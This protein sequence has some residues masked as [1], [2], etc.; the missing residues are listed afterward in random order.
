MPAI[1][2]QV[3]LA[4]AG[5]CSRRGGEALISAGR[6]TLN[7]VVAALGDKADHAGGDVVAVDGQL[8]ETDDAEGGGGS[9]DRPITYL[10]HKPAGVISTMRD[11]HGRPTVADM[12][13]PSPRVFPIG[14]LDKETTGLILAT[15]DGPLA[16]ALTHPSL[17][18]EK[19]YVLRLANPLPQAARRA[20]ARGVA[21]GDGLTAPAKVADVADGIDPCL[22]SLTIHEGR[23]RQI[24]RMC[25]ALGLDLC[26][27]A[28]V[29]IGP[30]SDPFLRPG[31]FR[32]LTDNEYDALR[33]KGFTA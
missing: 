17:G 15:A 5:L 16:H 24:R 31:S 29:R 13:P 21:L 9:S 33:Q 25:A 30:L 12:L 3:F 32:T 7:G 26:S 18:V 28:R 11:T 23:N 27:L 6:V 1:R 2:L 19:E 14:R 20:L 8:V 22:V 4:R 10:L